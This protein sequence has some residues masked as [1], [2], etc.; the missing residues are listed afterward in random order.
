MKNAWSVMTVLMRPIYL[1]GAY[2]GVT[3]EDLEGYKYP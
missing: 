3:V 1:L 2:I